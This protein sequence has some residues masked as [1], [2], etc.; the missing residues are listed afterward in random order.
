MIVWR[1]F[2]PGGTANYSTGTCHWTAHLHHQVFGW[3]WSQ[4]ASPKPPNDWGSELAILDTL[5][6]SIVL[7]S[8]ISLTIMGW[9]PLCRTREQCAHNDPFCLSILPSVWTTG[10]AKLVLMTHGHGTRLH[11]TFFQH[12]APANLGTYGMNIG[13]QSPIWSCE[14]ASSLLSHFSFLHQLETDQDGEEL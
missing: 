9:I 11:K 1:G 5:S 10:R 4:E 3:T 7:H 2:H 6:R 13:C 14:I 12:S 8:L